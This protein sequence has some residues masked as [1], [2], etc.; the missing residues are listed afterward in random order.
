[1]K[2]CNHLWMYKEFGNLSRER[3]YCQKCLMEIDVERWKDITYAFIVHDESPIITRN[4][5]DEQKVSRLK[6]KRRN[7]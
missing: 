4:A 7:T 5:Y 1:M 2:K 3:F 6:G